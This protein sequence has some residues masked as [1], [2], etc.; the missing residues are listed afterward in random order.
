MWEFN[1][2]AIVSDGALLYFE[3][4]QTEI[5]AYVL[6][7]DKNPTQLPPPMIVPLVE[8]M[9]VSSPSLPPVSRFTAG[10]LNGLAPHAVEFT[11]LSI[12]VPAQW[13]W[14]FGDGSTSTEPDPTHVYATAGTYSVSLTVTNASGSDTHI[15]TNLVVV[16][17]PIVPTADFEATP[18]VGGSPLAVTFTDLT[19]GNPTSWIWDFGDGTSSTQ[20]HPFR[21]FSAL[22]PYTVTLTTAT[23]AGSDIETKI[24]YITVEPSYTY[25]AVADSKVRAGSPN[26]NYGDEDD[27]RVRDDGLELN[28][29]E[30]YVRFEVSDLLGPVTGARLRFF[31]NDGSADSGTVYATSNSWGEMNITYGTAPGAVGDPLDTIAASQS[32]EFLEF[33]VSPAVSGNGIYSFYLTNDLSD[34]LELSSRE[35]EVPPQLVVDFSVEQQPPQAEFVGTPLSG[36]A[37][38][39][40][41]FTNQS[42]FGQNAAWSWDFGD[43]TGSA[44]ENPSHSYDTAGVYEVSL[45]VTDSAG[46]DTETKAEYIQVD[47]PLTA[48]TLAKSFEPSTILAGASTTITFTLSNGNSSALTGANFLDPYAGGPTGLVNASPLAIA[49]TCKDVTTV[50][51]AG[52]SSF[53]VV[54]ATIP[55]SGSCTISVEVTGATASGTNTTTVLRTNEAPD[56]LLGGS[57]E[58]RVA[59]MVDGFENGNLALWD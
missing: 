36:T 16:D 43:G 23:A 7:L 33:D 38:L 1:S 44:L 8:P 19:E 2:N 56:S 39:T 57:A 40:V 20:Q 14:N 17:P 9:F 47:P 22:G 32:E 13:L 28:T 49:G 4:F 11:D 48:P 30:S 31:V 55:A 15:K 34:N 25:F 52:G 46:T 53:E 5:H 18:Q 58:L 3:V 12:N 26:S 6:E 24:D 37:P 29:W 21:I 41:Q 10:S 35:G 51:S 50:A 42:L 54:S 45:E 59:V 27:L